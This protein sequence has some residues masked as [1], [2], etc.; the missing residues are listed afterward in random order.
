MVLIL[1]ASELRLR[2]CDTVQQ[3]HT[4]TAGDVLCWNGEVCPFYSSCKDVYLIFFRFSMAWMY[5]FYFTFLDISLT[6]AIKIPDNANDGSKLFERLSLVSDPEDVASCLGCIEGPYAF[7]FYHASDLCFASAQSHTSQASSKHLYFGR[8]PVGRR[9]L[10]VHSPTSKNPYFLLMSASAGE[11]AHYDGLQEV[12]TKS[13]F[14]LDLCTSNTQAE[15][16]LKHVIVSC[17]G[18]D[19][20][21]W[22]SGPIHIPRRIISHLPF[23]SFTP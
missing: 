17:A 4:N 6:R 23:V 22:A 8:D 2:G 7:A 15:V 1:F 10:L 12:S 9:S 16:R 3:P 21:M 14:Y 19:I 11:D 18:Q 20:Q 5:S 13:F